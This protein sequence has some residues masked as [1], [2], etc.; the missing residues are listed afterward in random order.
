MSYFA[1][2]QTEVSQLANGV[3]TENLAAITTVAAYSMELK[4]EHAYNVHVN[5]VLK[6]G[7]QKD[8]VQAFCSVV[9]WW[10]WLGTQAG[11]YFFGGRMTIRGEL[12]FEFLISYAGLFNQMLMALLQIFGAIPGLGSAV[13]SATKVFGIM[14][15]HPA[16]QAHV[17]VVPT[18]CD[19]AITFRDVD[20]TY[21]TR[22]KQPIFSKLNFSAL[23]GKSVA[24]AGESGCGKSSI[25]RLLQRNYEQSAGLIE[26][27]GIDIRQLNVA[28]LKSQIGVVSQEPV[29][30][31][32]TIEE[33]IKAGR[34]GITKEAVVEAAKLADA[35]GF[36]IAMADGCVPPPRPLP[37]DHVCCVFLGVSLEKS[38]RDVHTKPPPQTRGEVN[39][40]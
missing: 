32:G 21:P 33:N 22:T 8:F 4:A 2:K 29:L 31:S 18:S 40:F 27:D 14:I 7:I 39:P 28:W 17:G 15:R 24:L 35:H 36:I 3:A 23:P 37:P 12:T 38:D 19:G 9:L 30:F 25:L 34:K 13:G 20:F 26:L 16:V 11:I 1:K 6:L 10:S 5:R